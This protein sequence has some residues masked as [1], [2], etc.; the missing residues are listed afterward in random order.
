V[1]VVLRNPDGHYLTG[2][3]VRWEFTENLADATIFECRADQI[4]RQFAQDWRRHLLEAVPV[5]PD[6]I[7]EALP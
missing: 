6:E 5:F 3:P 7:Q 2:W 4:A 1:R